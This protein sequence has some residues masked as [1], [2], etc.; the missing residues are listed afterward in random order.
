MLPK[1]KGRP[2]AQDA[3]TAPSRCQM[4]P[5]EMPRRLL[6]MITDKAETSGLSRT[7]W[8]RRV[9]A[10]EVNFEFPRKKGAHT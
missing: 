6:E 7:A 8:V 1:R 5:V 9:L 2:R 4:A 10:R 3:R